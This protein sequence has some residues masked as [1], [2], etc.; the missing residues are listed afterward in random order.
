M[1]IPVNEPIVSKKAKKYVLETLETGW[2]SSAGKYVT[3]FEEKF[4][5]YLGVKYATTV[6]NGTTALHLALEALDIRAGDEI[7]IPDLTIISCALAA[8]YTGAK[9]ILVDVELE[10]G[11]IDPHLIEK[12]ITKRTKA[13]MVV[14]LYG[15]SVDMDPILKIAR[16]HNLFII[17]DAAEAHGAEYKGKKAGSMGDIACFSFYGNKIVT[18]GEGGMVVTNNKKLYEKACLFK[19][20]AHKPG[21]RFFHEKVGFNYR[22]TNIQAAMGLAHLEEIDRFIE[23]KLWMKN[24]Y[25]ELLSDIPFLELPI[26]QSYAKSVYWMYNLL[27]TK[28]S[29]INR[30]NF[31]KKLKEK[32]VDTRTYFY[33]LHTQ[34]VLKNKYHYNDKSYPVTNDLSARGLYL[35]SG[36]AITEHQ[37]KIVSQKIHEVFY[38]TK[39]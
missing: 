6:S 12:S 4:A 7:I 19:N 36:L 34:T 27:L 17:E 26:E 18:T 39:R 14:H 30:T 20:L 25:N 38:E 22:L 2:I 28:N 8:L 35:P 9:P 37:I 29:P 31:M 33:P 32:G 10:N 3:Q 15:H 5:E 23:K 24:L 16:K 21:K 13:I 11:N 1:M